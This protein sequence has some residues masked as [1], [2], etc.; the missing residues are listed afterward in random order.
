M[1]IKA[2]CVDEKACFMAT[3]GLTRA[4]MF[5]L[6]AFKAFTP[7]Q[8]QQQLQNVHKLTLHARA[9]TFQWI[10]VRSRERVYKVRE[11][12]VA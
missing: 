3:L 2:I 10:W 11:M 1:A 8:Q 9:K 5:W 6:K 4:W 7:T 12:S